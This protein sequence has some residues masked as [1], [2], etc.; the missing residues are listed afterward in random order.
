MHF[1]CI[2]ALLFGLNAFMRPIAV[3]P[4]AA[5]IVVTED[6]LRQLAG[7]WQVQWG[8]APTSDELRRLVE[9]QV[10]EEVLIREALAAGLERQDILVRRRLAALAGS[11][12]D[13][14]PPPQPSDAVLRAFYEAS[15]ES[16]SVPADLTL[17]QLY[18]SDRTRNGR[19]K[20]E[21]IQARDA[22]SGRGVSD[23]AAASL[24]DPSEFPVRLEAQTPEELAALFGQ[25]FAA[26]ASRLPVGS[27]QGPVPSLGG[28]HLVFIE[29]AT[30]G[31]PPAFE[32][33]REAVLQSWQQQWRDERQRQAYAAMR[34]RYS[35]ALPP[36]L[37]GGVAP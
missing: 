10:R 3:P 7:L 21:A 34:A 36:S 33:V 9:E 28:W 32:T 5:R 26:V 11:E 1:V 37:A 23:P 30:P 15:R 2:G 25:P 24:G 6:D 8:R 16:F 12:A 20:E 14:G 31:P 22:L 35:V 13:A 27:W 17:T 29:A 4:S 19:S 18:F